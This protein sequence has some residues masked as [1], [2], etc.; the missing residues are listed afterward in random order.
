MPKWH[1]RTNVPTFPEV[2]FFL[3]KGGATIEDVAERL[4]MKKGDK[5]VSKT[6]KKREGCSDAELKYR[7]LFEQSPYGIAIHDAQGKILDFNE[8][9]H[10][11]LGYAREE[12]AR[13]SIADIDPVESAAEIQAHIGLIMR[14]G[15]KEFE[16]KHRTKQ[17]EIRDVY[18]IAKPL[19][20]SGRNIIHAIWRDITER[21]RMEEALL[22]SETRYR[23]LFETAGDG[24][25][26]LDCNGEDAGRIV[27]A[28]T[29]AAKMHGYAVDELLS[30][31][32]TDLD[33]PETARD[34]PARMKRVLNGE[35]I[36]AEVTHRKKDGT[37]FPLE[38]SARLIEMRNRKYILAFERDI[39]ERKQAEDMLRKNDE[40]IRNILDNVDQG[41]LVIDRNFRIVTANNGYCNLTG[42]RRDEIIGRRCYEVS[43]KI[44]KPCYEEGEDCAVVKVFDTGQPHAAMHKHEDAKGN[45]MYVETRAFPLRDPSGA[46]T[47]AIETIHN[48]TERQLLEEEQLK[49]QK[50][51]AIGTLAGGIAHDFNNLLQGVFGYISMAKVDLDRRG[52]A[53]ADLEQAEKALNVSINLTNQLLTFSKGGKPVKKRF[54]LLPVIESSA[55]FA[56]SGSRSHY[57]LI[58]DDELWPAEA[59]EGQ[60]A[61]VIQNIVLNADEAM[62][63][64]GIVEISARNV[65][66]RRGD[67]SAFSEGGR[68]ISIVIKDAGVGIPQQYLSRIFDPYF[69]TKQKGSGLGLATSYSIIRN[70]GGAME[71]KSELSRGSIFS[72]Y[73]PASDAQEEETSPS[74]AP[75]ESVRKGRILLMDDEEIVRIVASM[76][77]KSLGHDITCTEN[78]ENAIEKFSEAM[79]SGRPFD[80]VI[81]DLTVKGNMGGAQA[82]V[83]LRQIDPAVKIIVSSGYSDS[84]AVSSYR[85]YGFAASLNK[86][87]TIET[88]R[89]TL[90]NMLRRS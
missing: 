17:G 16:V 74:F 48:I 82:A 90:N 15:G 14:D 64:G 13:L 40:L 42:K 39:T 50:L 32:I 52:K 78:G 9:A 69:T 63:D 76:M 5:R 30:M 1:S 12:F 67:K 3:I 72:I 41:F 77:V 8:A 89:D 20:L 66:L 35:L 60:I 6:R 38:I 25:L 83:E 80:V 57:R 51:E 4:Q 56:L 85:S 27:S 24:I 61:Q 75:V 10:R 36:Q 70:H 37:V 45:I 65:D 62:P 79:R 47:A 23:R 34:V 31:N 73:L 53:F 87:Y 2:G 21:K 71:V 7:T 58:H 33:T 22:E 11:D 84:A 86:P 54:N 29:A 26:I 28:N 59:D 19:T 46:V 88:L 68:F 18:V 81:L 44:P 55:R 43:H 49:S